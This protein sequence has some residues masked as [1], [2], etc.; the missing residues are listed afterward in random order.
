MR[1]EKQVPIPRLANAQKL[2]DGKVVLITGGS[3]GIGFAMA[4]AFLDS[5]AKVIISG[6]NEGKLRNCVEQL[7]GDSFRE[8][9]KPLALH[10]V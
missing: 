8:T 1:T 3:G 5:G 4:K 2:L 6:T 9:V 7:G 10:S